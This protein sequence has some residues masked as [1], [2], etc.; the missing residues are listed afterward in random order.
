MVSKE[1]LLRLATI[2]PKCLLP[3]AM[4]WSCRMRKCFLLWVRKVRFSEIALFSCVSSLALNILASTACRTSNPLFLRLAAIFT[5]TSSSRYR[6]MNSFSPGKLLTIPFYNIFGNMLLDFIAVVGVVTQGVKYLGKGKMR[7]VFKN[8]LRRCP[9]FP[10][11][12]NSAYRRS[13]AFD[14]R[15]STEDFIVMNNIWMFRSCNH[16]NKPILPC[17]LKS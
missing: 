6:E 2:S 9:K 17:F 10:P 8:F 5:E 14:N 15:L 3:E 11:F 1:F 12:N 4:Y 13:R 16:F 7:E